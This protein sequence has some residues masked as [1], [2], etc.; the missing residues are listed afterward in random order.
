MPK[1]FREAFT[2]TRQRTATRFRSYLDRQTHRSFQLTRRRDYERQLEIPGYWSL[3]NQVRKTLWSQKKIFFWLTVFYAVLTAVLV[4]VG[5]QDAY[6]ILNTT[7]RDTGSNIFQGDWGEIGVAG[8]LFAS[9]ATSGLTGAVT[10]AQQIYTAI[11]LLLVWLTTVW[12]LRQAMAHRNVRLR[13]GLYNAGSPIVP[14]FLI[15]L[16]LLLQLVPLGV[17]MIGYSAATSSGLLN[18][19]VEAMLFWVAAALLAILSLYWIVSTFFALVIVTLP[20]TYP[21]RALRTAGAIV[22]GRRVKLLLRILWMILGIVVAWA[23]VLIPVILLDS[24]LKSWIPAI[25]A[26]PIV[27]IVLLILGTVTTIWSAA[28]IYI[29]YRK[30]VEYDAAE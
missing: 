10:E 6:D 4:G 15:A 29:L 27:P 22:A 28:Y 20:G 19:G 5:S 21:M 30:V 17:A 25:A 14:T 26:A 1:S 11:L 9:V 12:L 3:T 23:F 7:L 16:V 8:L 13:D 24:G 2:E 18:G